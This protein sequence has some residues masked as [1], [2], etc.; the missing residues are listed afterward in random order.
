MYSYTEFDD[1]FLAERNAQFR[2]Q[3]DRRLDGPLTEDA[4]HPLPLLHGLYLPLPPHIPP[5]PPP[6]FPPL[7]PPSSFPPPSSPPSPL[8]PRPPF[9]S[10]PT[11]ASNLIAMSAT[12]PLDGCYR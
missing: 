2:A 5:V 9:P 3:V 11:L 4:F 6:P 8:S 7:S 12:A 10:S 1:A